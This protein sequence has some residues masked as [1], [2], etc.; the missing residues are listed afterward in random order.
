MNI[1]NTDFEGEDND[2]NELSINQF[3]GPLSMKLLFKVVNQYN[4]N[5]GDDEDMILDPFVM[6]WLQ[7]NNNNHNNHKN[8]LKDLTDKKRN[9]QIKM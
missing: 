2:A 8:S 9:T 7:T 6:M 5:E 1:E 3:A 4:S